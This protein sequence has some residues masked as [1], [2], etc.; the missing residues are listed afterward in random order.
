MLERHRKRQGIILSYLNKLGILDI[1]MIMKLNI[2]GLGDTT[3]RNVLRVMQNLEERGLIKSVRKEVK[4]FM[5]IDRKYS[6]IEHRLMM[7]RF[8][9]N[10]G[11]Y[12]TVKLEPLIKISGEEFR[13]DFVVPKIDNP[14]LATDWK[15]FEVDRTQKKNVNMQKAKRYKD[16]GL[17]FEVVCGIE[18]VY[19]WKGFVY[20]VV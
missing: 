3:K 16:L 2:D 9:C 7:N 18:R 10:N 5:L 19:M 11:Y 17:Q 8:I 15:Y 1:D 20:H 6:H 4:L 14:K 13:P 12:H